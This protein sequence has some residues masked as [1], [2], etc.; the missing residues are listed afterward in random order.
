MQGCAL[1][2][3]PQPQPDYLTGLQDHHSDAGMHDDATDELASEC[4]A[5]DY[6]QC[7]TERTDID[8][9]LQP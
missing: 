3:S 5:E 8:H 7:I 6:A 9:F 4:A 1:V 2:E